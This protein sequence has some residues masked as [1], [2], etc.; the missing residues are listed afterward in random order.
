M[1]EE[2]HTFYLNESFCLPLSVCAVPYFGTL[3]HKACAA[4]QGFRSRLGLD[5]AFSFV[6]WCL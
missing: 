2:C 5:L 6:T 1:V 3:R 4:A